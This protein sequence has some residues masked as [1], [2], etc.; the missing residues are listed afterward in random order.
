MRL[1]RKPV[2]FDLLGNRLKA[3]PKNG[4]FVVK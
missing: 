1:D 4:M 2:Y 3:K